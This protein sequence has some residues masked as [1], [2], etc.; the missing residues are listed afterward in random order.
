M[1]RALP[2]QDSNLLDPPRPPCRRASPMDRGQRAK[3]AAPGYVA[4]AF[5]KP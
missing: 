3:R 2:L 5:S 1:A 4:N